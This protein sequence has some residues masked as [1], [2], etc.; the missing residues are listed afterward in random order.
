MTVKI[1]TEKDFAQHEGLGL[2]DVT[3]ERAVSQLESFQVLKADL[4]AV[5]KQAV[6]ERFKLSAY[7]FR[8]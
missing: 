2:I 8:L 1:V 4:Y 5:F 7:G 6:A 3:D